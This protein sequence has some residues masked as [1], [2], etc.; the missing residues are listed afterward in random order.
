MLVA[1]YLFY[2]RFPN[3]FTSPNFY[4]E[5]GSV[6]GAS[7]LHHGFLHS[8]ETTFN[9]Y[10]IWGIYLV[11]KL[12]FL[13]DGVR[14]GKQ[15]VDLPQSLALA[16]YLFLGFVATLPALLFRKYLKWP[17]LLLICTL[18]VFVPLLGYDYAVI[19]TIGNLKFAFAYIAFLLLIYRNLISDDSNAF[20]AVDIGLLICA[21]TDIT[22]YLMMP[23]AL[24]R[25][26]KGFKFSKPYFMGLL[27]TRSFQSLIVLGVALLPQLYVV[28]KD[29]VP[30]LPGYLDSAYQPAKTVELFISRSYLF[31][32]LY[33]INKHLN[34]AEVVIVM[35]AFLGGAWFFLKS[36]F[37]AI[38]LFAIYSIFVATFLFVIKRT[39]VS[40]LFS[41]YSTSGPDQFFY[42]Q[43]W[44]F[45]FIFAIALQAAF[46]KIRL[47][48]VQI[49]VSL[50][51]VVG[52]VFI[53]IP[54]AGNYGKSN[55]MAENVGTVFVDAH[56]VCT[57]SKDQTLNLPIYPSQVESFSGISR[58]T[59][60]TP[61]VLA[62]EP[63]DVSL[64]LVPFNN[65]YLQLANGTSFTQSF[66]SPQNNLSGV[67][68]YFS[69]FGATVHSPY[70]FKLLNATCTDTLQTVRIDTGKIS[71]NALF[72]FGFSPIAKA[73][74][75]TYCFSVARASSTTVSPLAVQLS[76]PGKYALGTTTINGKLEADTVVFSLHYKD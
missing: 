46:Q 63:P 59:L 28:H 66:V 18:S 64:G 37:R 13:I 62:Y 29:G 39:G 38:L 10:Y 31:P 43:N 33:P 70:T 52:L 50:L 21:Y 75:M 69:T 25:Y 48:N 8:M 44:M 56:T 60:C 16:S 3:N 6:F 72:T 36:R 57:T 4:A 45:I 71:D 76:A 27:R 67:N 74:N 20:Y 22:V 19:G 41:H 23:F 54:H 1:S 40:A 51:I 73:K 7:I 61:S 32:I 5:D 11:E 30:A 49:L 47:H 15:F 34:N 58:S 53:Y 9:G 26:A 14:Y 42:A 12:G 68:V 17:T 55:F 24:L 35:L 65:N 2:R